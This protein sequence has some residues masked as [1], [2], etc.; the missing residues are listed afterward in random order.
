MSPVAAMVQLRHPPQNRAALPLFRSARIQSST[1][2]P[3]HFDASAP[4]L[5]LSKDQLSHAFRRAS[6]GIAD[7]HL[8]DMRHEAIGRICDRLPMHE[9]LRI[10]GHKTPNFGA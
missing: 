4:L 8:H 5:P 9:A 3:G 10:T 2:L 7:L 1:A 6:A